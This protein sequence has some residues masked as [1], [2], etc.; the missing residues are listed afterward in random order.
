MAAKKPSRSSKSRPRTVR[1]TH[2]D[3]K[4]VDEQDHPNGFSGV[5]ADAVRFYREQR[6]DARRKLLESF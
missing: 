4:W 2:S 1:L 3:E 6:D 5:I